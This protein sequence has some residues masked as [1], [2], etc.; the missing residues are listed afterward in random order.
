MFCDKIYILLQNN[1]WRW[2]RASLRS[3]IHSLRIRMT[4]YPCNKYEQIT[5]S[6]HLSVKHTMFIFYK[7]KISSGAIAEPLWSHFAKIAHKVA[8]SKCFVNI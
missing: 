2:R 5:P 4:S 8:K 1:R 3:S 6:Y 7:F